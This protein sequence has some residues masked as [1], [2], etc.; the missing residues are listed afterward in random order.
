MIS[1]SASVD[2][3]LTS[4]KAGQ[5]EAWNYL[6]ARYMNQFIR[7]AM[8]KQL[9]FQDAEEVANESLEQ[10]A[11]S[12]DQYAGRCGEGWLWTI[13]KHKVIDRRR[14]NG[15]VQHLELLESYPCPDKDFSPE[16]S[17]EHN[18][19]VQAF[20]RAWARLPLWAQETL[21]P[22][23]RGRKNKEWGKA[24]ELLKELMIEEE[25]APRVHAHM[26]FSMTG[27]KTG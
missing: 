11:L 16:F 23:R 25:T 13:H 5:D 3:L 12:I 26:H 8:K 15:S 6:Y 10:V 1:K 19:H 4:L 2:E 9:S 7:Y 24:K 27:L 17:V 18:D 14:I 21:Q 22:D 20:Q